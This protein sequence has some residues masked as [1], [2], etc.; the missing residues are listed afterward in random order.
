MYSEHVPLFSLGAHDPRL[1]G[2]FYVPTSGTHTHRAATFR[3]LEI[4]HDCLLFR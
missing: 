1:N 4:P 3:A 2:I